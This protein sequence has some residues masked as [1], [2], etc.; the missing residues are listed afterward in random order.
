MSFRKV[1]GAEIGNRLYVGDVPH[2]QTFTFALDIMDQTNLHAAQ[3]AAV[4]S[5][6][7]SQ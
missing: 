7:C 3:L 4:A 5:G 2:T 1:S 6:T